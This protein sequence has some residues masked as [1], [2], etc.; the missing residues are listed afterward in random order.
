MAWLW[1]GLR[2]V[3]HSVAAL[4]VT[5]VLTLTWSVAAGVASAAL[6]AVGVTTVAAREA[7][8]LAT[9]RL[10]V[11]SAARQAVARTRVIATRAVVSLPTKLAPVVGAAAVVGVTAWDLYDTCSLAEALTALEDDDGLK[12][13]KAAICGLALPDWVSLPSADQLPPPQQG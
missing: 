12:K 10:A 2:W 11:R 1:F 3:R 5:N 7:G 4:L 13:E 6:G 8:R 9:R